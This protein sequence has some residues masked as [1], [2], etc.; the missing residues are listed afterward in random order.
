MTFQQAFALDEAEARALGNPAVYAQPYVDAS[1]VVHLPVTT[2][3]AQAAATQPILVPPDS[4]APDDGTDN[5]DAVP[6]PAETRGKGTAPTADTP[7]KD[8]TESRST[9]IENTSEVIPQTRV[10]RHT[11]ERLQQIS[12]EIT[13]LTPADLPDLDRIH[14]LE[15]DPVSGRVIVGATEATGALRTALAAR[16]G[17]DAVALHVTP[18][19]GATLAVN[20]QTDSSPY[21]GG[22]MYR[23]NGKPH[24]TTGF[25][26][27][28]RG[29][30]YMLTAGHCVGVGNYPTSGNGQEMGMV[31]H[32]IFTGAANG[33]VPIGDKHHG[34]LA[35]I[36]MAYGRSALPKTYVGNKNSGSS[37]EGAGMSSRRN[38]P[39]DRFC[40]GGAFGGELCYWSVK[41]TRVTI[42]EVE[43]G[44]WMRNVVEAQRDPGRRWCVIRGD[45]G[46]PV[47]AL[48]RQGK[49]RAKGIINA[50]NLLEYNCHIWF[51]DIHD[52]HVRLPGT[53]K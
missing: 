6:P 2:A 38:R 28:Y 22:A 34:D 5:P 25:A 18:R 47:Y 14:R 50:T 37:R 17:G 20:R 11:W 23:M 8:P 35:L 48:N 49:V 42:Q 3:E 29:D 44:A 16:Y 15:I 41:R 52:A 39:G 36:K 53:V 46:G 40:T 12:D 33:S 26:W 32:D 7:P 27:D 30:H 24:C 31:T 13:R 43:G 19:P 4:A 51:T 10:V 1:G 9:G 21:F 45:S